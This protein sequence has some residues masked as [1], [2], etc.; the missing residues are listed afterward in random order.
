MDG[1]CVTFMKSVHK[2]D[3]TRSRTIIGMYVD[4][5]IVA[6]DDEKM[7]EQLSCRRTSS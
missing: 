6:T 2:E 4:D 3:G 1:D 5:G 7:Y